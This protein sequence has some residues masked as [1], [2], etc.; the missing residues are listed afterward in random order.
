METK[1]FRGLAGGQELEVFRDF[2]RRHVERRHDQESL[3]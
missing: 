2:L 3:D 1:Y